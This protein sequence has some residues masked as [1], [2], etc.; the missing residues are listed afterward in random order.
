MHESGSRGKSATLGRRIKS[1]RALLALKQADVAAKLGVS[2]TTVMKWETGRAMP[3]RE[4][5]F[6]LADTLGV[7]ADWLMR[8]EEAAT[9][10]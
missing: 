1:R 4:N 5:L 10:A 3:G 8:G 2:D 9:A 6:A 7:S